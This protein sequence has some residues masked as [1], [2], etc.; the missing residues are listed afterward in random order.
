MSINTQTLYTQKSLQFG[1][2]VSQK[3]FLSDFI[4]AVN[5]SLSDI[6]Q[7]VGPSGTALED[8][9]ADVD[10]DVKYEPLLSICVDFHLAYMG[11]Y[12]GD[13]QLLMGLKRG[14]IK[15]ARMEYMK[16]DITVDGTAGVKGKFGD[17]AAQTE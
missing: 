16:N 5:R 1:T 12:T 6:A 15:Q 17:I 9:N 4:Q 11:G 7:M 2:G 14:A 13:V 10:I 3:R 8:I